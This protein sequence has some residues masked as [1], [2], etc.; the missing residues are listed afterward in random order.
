MRAVLTFAAALAL[1]A[2]AA[3]AQQALGE[4]VYRSSCAMCHQA[5]G[6]GA[7][8]LAPPLKGKQWERLAAAGAYVP[9]VLLAGMHGPIVT[10]EGTFVGVMPTQNRLS[11]DEIAAVSAYLV[12]DI[13]GRQGAPLATAAE[14]AAWRARPASVA[15]LRAMRKQALAK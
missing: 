8:G 7:A 14:V 13:N 5:E 12:R 4:Q 2:G 1:A 15:E 3:Q 10:D 11:D 9:G 6:Q